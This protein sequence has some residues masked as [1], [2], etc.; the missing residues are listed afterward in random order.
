[1]LRRDRV[2]ASVAGV[3]LGL[4]IV[5]ADPDVRRLLLGPWWPGA[6]PGGGIRT[7]PP[8]A[9]LSPAEG[10]SWEAIVDHEST[11]AAQAAGTP[12]LPPREGP[13]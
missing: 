1:M 13:Q 10:A 3:V 2:A 5:W 9:P 4:A 6:D 12:Y 8:G 7:E 11:M